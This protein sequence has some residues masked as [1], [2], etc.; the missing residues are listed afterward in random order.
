ATISAGNAL[1]NY[2][3]TVG[4]LRQFRTKFELTKP[5]IVN[6]AILSPHPWISSALPGSGAACGGDDTA[7]HTASDRPT[8]A[9]SG[10]DRQFDPP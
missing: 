5:G 1:P 10:C 9:V 6:R 4:N 3:G 2:C 7:R 8:T